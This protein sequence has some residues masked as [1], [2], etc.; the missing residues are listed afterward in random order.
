M[1]KN[2]KM[3]LS[4]TAD[5]SQAKR[6]IN[7]L[8]SKL[9]NLGKSV[10]FGKGFGDGFVKET[11]K[12]KKQIAE[13]QTALSSATNV[14]TGKLDFTKF[15]QQLKQSGTTLAEYGRTLNS[16]GTEGQEAFIQLARAV[17]ASEVPMIRISK[18]VKEL[19]NT[20]A[21]T[22]RW[23]ISSSIL[24]G[25]MGAIQQA[26]GYAQ[27]LNESLN[28]IRIVTNL[29]TQ[30]MAQFAEQANR[31]AQNLG[32][33]T[34]NYTDAALIYY[35]QGIRDQE[36]IAQ[37]TETTIKLAN[38]TKASAEEVSSQMTAIWNNFYDGSESLESYAD[39]ITALGA[40]TASSSA[41]IAQGLEK[42]AAVADTVG[43]SYDQATAALATVVAQTRQSADIVGTAFKTLFARL[44]SLQLGETLDDG[45]TLNK[46]SKALETVGVNIFQANGQLKDMDVILNDLGTRWQTLDKNS[47]VALAQT[48]GGMRQYNQLI[49][50]MD[51]YDKFQD[52]L[53]I[54]QEAEGTLQEQQDIYA[55]S[56]E[57][58]TKRVKAAWEALYKDI[59]ED[60]FFIELNDNLAKLLDGLD[61]F[62]DSLGGIKGL[63]V[64]ISPLIYS[65]FGDKIQGV[66][67]NFTSSIAM[68]LPGARQKAID[69]KNAFVNKAIDQA[70]VMGDDKSRIQLSFEKEQY[71]TI[72][73]Y[74]DKLT[75]QDKQHLAILRDQKIAQE[76]I[77]QER[78]EELNI[79]EA[80]VK[81]EEKKQEKNIAGL[82]LTDIE[83]KELAKY[84]YQK[85]QAWGAQELIGGEI[86]G[87]YSPELISRVNVLKEKYL[88]DLEDQNDG[89]KNTITAIE[90]NERSIKEDGLT[91]EE[92]SKKKKEIVELYNEISNLLEDEVSNLSEKTD[93]KIRDL[94]S[95]K[96][97]GNTEE[98]N[99]GNR[100]SVIDTFHSSQTG[101]NTRNRVNIWFGKNK[102][103]TGTKEELQDLI[104]VTQSYVDDLKQ[105]K[106]TKGLT[107]E[108]QKALDEYT[109]IL[110]KAKAQQ[111]KLNKAEEKLEEEVTET[112][113]KVSEQAGNLGIVEAQK[114]ELQAE[115]N[116]AYD[117]SKKEQGLDE[118]TKEMLERREAELG[119]GLNNTFGGMIQT[120]TSLGSAFVQLTSVMNIWDEVAKGNVSV[121]QALAQTMSTAALIIPT[122]SSS[123]K[124]LISIAAGFKIIG[125]AL[126]SVQRK[127]AIETLN[128]IML[129][130]AYAVASKKAAEGELEQ[131]ATSKSLTYSLKTLGNAYAAA[132][133]PFMVFVAAV[134][135]AIYVYQKYK[136]EMEELQEIQKANEEQRKELAEQRKET[137]QILDQ[138]EALKELSKEVEK[139][140]ST[141]EDYNKKITEVAE[142]LEIENVQLQE[143]ARLYEYLAQKIKEAQGEKVSEIENSIMTES[144]LLR[145][146]LESEK[147]E[148][149][150]ITLWG[151]IA[152][153]G[154]TNFLGAI[155]GPSVGIPLGGLQNLVGPEESVYRRGFE[156]EDEDLLNAIE[157]GISSYGL[158]RI[159]QVTDDGDLNVDWSSATDAQALK[160]IRVLQDVTDEF[161]YLDSGLLK[162]INSQIDLNQTEQTLA[163]N[164]AEQ[165]ANHIAYNEDFLEQ[166]D[167]ITTLS[168]INSLVNKVEVSDINSGYTQDT[169]HS[170]L[171]SALQKGNNPL[172]LIYSALE[173]F[174]SENNLDLN[175][176]TEYID[177]LNLTDEELGSVVDTIIVND[178]LAAAYFR[179][180]KNLF[181]TFI[182]DI[183]TEIE[184]LDPE[185]ALQ[186][187][188]SIQSAIDDLKLGKEWINEEEFA[189]FTKKLGYEDPAK[190]M[191]LQPNAFQK[192]EDGSYKFIG[193]IEQLYRALTQQK[194]EEISNKKDTAENE[195]LKYQS[196]LD[197]YMDGDNDQR[198]LVQNED[199]KWELQ[200]EGPE[201]LTSSWFDD[202]H[203]MDEQNQK[204]DDYL[205]MVGDLIDKLNEAQ[206]RSEVNFTFGDY[207]NGGTNLEDLQELQATIDG[208]S[209]E[210]RN[211]LIPAVLE[212]ASVMKDG[213]E[214]VQ[215]YAEY[216]QEN[217]KYLKDDAKYTYE[218]ALANSLFN[219]GLQ[220]LADNIDTWS[221]SLTN[222]T[223]DSEKYNEAING[224]ETD[225]QQVFSTDEDISKDFIL[226]HLEDI[227]KAATG[228][229]EAIHNLQIAYARMQMEA[230]QYG[231][232]GGAKQALKEMGTSVEE[233]WNSIE[234]V[235]WED[236]EIGASLDVD[237]ALQALQKFIVSSQMTA[238]Q[239][240]E[241]LNSI[242]YAAEIETEPVEIAG[243]TVQ[244]VKSIKSAYYSGTN[245][246]TP[247]T[248]STSSKGKSGSS[249]SKKDK[250]DY[251]DEFERYYT[252]NRQIQDQI[253]EVERLGK[254]KDRAWGK[255]K[256]DLLDKE[257]DALQ[258]QIDLQNEKIRQV[259]Q[260]Y[261]Y[262]Q[263]R[264][265]FFGAQYDEN[266]V[267]TNYDEIVKREVDAYN[268]AV[269]RYNSGGSESAFSM[270]EDRYNKFKE[271]LKQYDETNQLWQSEMDKLTDLK[272]EYYDMQLE[273]IQTKVEM[274]IEVDDS[275]LKVLEYELDRI[276]K[277]AFS[278]AEAIAKIGEQ[279]DVNL[280][281]QKVYNDALEDILANHGISDIGEVNNLDESTIANLGF[282]QDEIKALEEYNE[283]LMDTQK[284]LD[285]LEEEI[286]NGPVEA[287]KEWNDE[288]DYQE[289]KIENNI[290]LLK[291]YK[292]IAD[293][294]YSNSR[295]V[296]DQFLYGIMNNTYN[297]MVTGVGA[298]YTEWQANKAAL[299]EAMAA[300]EESIAAGA[301]EQT[302][303]L[304]RNNLREMEEMV[305]KSRDDMLKK[306]EDA[307][308]QAEDLLKQFVENAAK[309]VKEAFSATDWDMTKFDRLK[310]LDDEYLDDY[311][312]IYELS[313]LTR[314]VNNSIDDMD[315]I[316]A[317]ERL[318]EIT[319]E[320]AEI[321][322][323]NREISQYEVDAL[324]KKY[325]LRLAEIALEDAQ[326]AK[327]TVRMSRDNDGNWSYVYTADDSKVDKARQNYEDKLYEYQK[328]NSEFIKNQQ[329]NFLKLEQEYTDAM[330]KIAEDSSLNE[331]DK[332]TRLQET[333]AYYQRMAEIMTDQLGIALDKNS[334]LYHKDWLDYSKMTD[335]KISKLE[336]YQTQIE[337]TYTGYLQP[338]IESAMD[339]LTQFT[340]ATV[341]EGGYFP[342]IVQGL[343]E[344]KDRQDE[345][346][347]ATGTTLEDYA[348]YVEDAM[349]TAGESSIK[350]SD[351]VSYAAN[352]MRNAFDEVIAKINELNQKNLS[353]LRSDISST[354]N[355]INSLVGAYK[356]LSQ[357]A[358]NT[359][360]M[361]KSATAAA[362]EFNKVGGSGA[363]GG[364]GSSTLSST[365]GKS[366]SG[367]TT[368]TSKS[369]TPA[370]SA[371]RGFYNEL[372]YV[373]SRQ[374]E[375]ARQETLKGIFGT[376]NTNEIEKIM[377]NSD[378]STVQKIRTNAQRITP[379]IYD[380]YKFDT[381]G[382]TG[383]WGS[384]GRWAMLH[385]KELVLNAHDT[386]N[387][388]NTIQMVRD[389]VASI[390]T[391]AAAAGAMNINAGYAGNAS[392]GAQDLNQNVHIEASF[393][394]ATDHNEIE[395]ALTNLVNRASQYA[396]RK[397]P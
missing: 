269:D 206:A 179:Q 225:L 394:N 377:L 136:Q 391:R 190:L 181:N 274:D 244:V 69:N 31:A 108:Q 342:Q 385:Q 28:N 251:K 21:N 129:K 91:Q 143:Q 219:N 42:F 281:K 210:Y 24:H 104:D 118:F 96:L 212:S 337:F 325:E 199:G 350:A 173:E 208:T 90:E 103:F 215:A 205:T 312:K 351:E 114:R 200:G 113:G 40:A 307:L 248:K 375:K 381:G 211:N 226:T 10:D 272:N 145:G 306:T 105:V 322:E 45:V 19:G 153:E 228:D 149:D 297:N 157:E 317:K 34:L 331:E 128:L 265:N 144:G 368:I 380:K 13:L 220:D 386:E 83:S 59:I 15:N 30:A 222:A 92:I 370:P 356:D 326:T 14:D 53:K 283:S 106:K 201:H 353:S 77:N 321:E 390:D 48:V 324:R 63:L 41:E 72:I 160:M 147:I 133:G 176:L 161:S 379:S 232:E 230:A 54:V 120:V 237:P 182:T 252:I 100:S 256:L 174:A 214:N 156:A 270:A 26:Y 257:S 60:D 392:A 374:P 196:L 146:N 336:D 344:F 298:A 273:K 311:E 260:Y 17:S 323:S 11:Q 5:A 234:N 151:N 70:I 138:I 261:K 286:L 362:I 318:K 155:L 294:I 180:D 183:Q 18:T 258:T 134:G 340:N 124:G 121:G 299:A 61:K 236:I 288:F 159:A 275:D 27:D 8:Q 338:N 23:Q 75:E 185:T 387:M 330:Q 348:M 345:I 67:Q 316:R 168:G 98:N 282:T 254:A 309:A 373:T 279:L 346:L 308:K 2:L 150:T 4:I 25:F 253:D 80:K 300:Y 202:Q 163:S 102:N 116:Q 334:E 369:G 355:S 188:S 364:G 87:R 35:Q 303:T 62:I 227:K 79:I 197:Y 152:A 33:S 313:K 189:K 56:W 363:G 388:L 64:A 315:T 36:E 175:A 142:A 396:G 243:Q 376:Y 57:A 81:Q 305:D 73:K 259:E 204:V 207:V 132:Y 341:G 47:K 241:I 263:E 240:T 187:L 343:E 78:E 50:L 88:Q 29:D 186:A 293:L 3:D 139:G 6:E 352:N 287:F 378:V 264:L 52:N 1:P 242:G 165:Y 335:Y 360:Q 171:I 178:E 285:Q 184:S 99:K 365:D 389:I 66:V 304:L 209:D 135:A 280:D 382:Y 250:K 216:L 44:E 235:K 20:L 361:L 123:L 68:M 39:K 327:N 245:K 333:Q 349:Y 167:N 110:K 22:L 95:K 284:E 328:L 74:G 125:N 193:N 127:E 154:V 109:K 172:G 229:M 101:I 358:Y 203:A 148:N 314:D 119:E 131:L 213:A 7:D 238:E 85:G 9:S 383:S 130:K 97:K 71:D 84:T 111:E 76:E 310:T 107:E 140:T 255:A 246:F 192:F 169:V 58:S 224:I 366:G 46:Y 38:V 276:R 354:V 290:N 301:D 233:L 115:G 278:T 164:L 51:N 191:E 277:K 198:K 112:A 12:A 395:L 267:V 82:N 49:A 266:G 339:L 218:V 384:E 371:L 221:D 295:G 289:D 117:N 296:T 397:K 357:Q 43:L 247:K 158:E 292:N 137:Q 302:I 223:K 217:N 37:R 141:K 367:Y 271:I 239:A 94:V 162:H 332:L 170:G 262:D 166:T 55:E 347:H 93:N 16:L 320:I 86:V 393:P 249:R 65:V 122:L 291:Q 177:K 126:S 372:I 32:T 195:I 268:K 89:I 359:Q 231:A 319:Q 194:I 329:E